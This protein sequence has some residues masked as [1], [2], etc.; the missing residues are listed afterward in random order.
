MMPGI[1]NITEEE[2]D[3]EVFRSK[4]NFEITYSW[5]AR[6][7][8]TKSNSRIHMWKCITAIKRWK[9]LIIIKVIMMKWK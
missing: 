1:N 2:E 8:Q 3:A 4:S 7:R 9:K 6:A 5:C